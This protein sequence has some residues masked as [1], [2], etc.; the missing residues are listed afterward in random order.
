MQINRAFLQFVPIM[1]ATLSLAA[2]GEP[3]PH[4]GDSRPT[5]PPVVRAPPLPPP[6]MARRPA[7]YTVPPYT[8]PP[9]AD[10]PATAFDWRDAPLPAG[11][12]AWVPRAGG[13]EARYGPGGQPPIAIMV[14]DRAAGV[15]RLALPMTA[16]MTGPMTGAMT[17][18]MT[19]MPTDPQQNGP[20]R[21][22]TITTSTST[23]TFVAHPEAIGALSTLAVTLPVSNR[24]LDAMAYSRGRFRVEIGGMA[25][26]LLPSWSEVGRLVEDCRGHG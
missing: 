11:D 16:P 17:G 22:A 24:M 7:P 2:C 4:A 14:C 20:T 15:V 1:V 26:V 25:P 23:S 9:T 18:A 13:S 19:G 10:A 3:P 8:P 21:S 12:W 6:P 5:A